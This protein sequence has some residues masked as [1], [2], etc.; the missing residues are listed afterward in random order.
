MVKEETLEANEGNLSHPA[1]WLAVMSTFPS[2][3]LS[4]IQ[5]YK[6]QV[7]QTP[8]GTMKLKD[9]VLNLRFET[10]NYW[11]YCGF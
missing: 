11:V 4:E 2:I 7:C 9:K 8:P 3:L 1:S 6:L 5:H 10:N